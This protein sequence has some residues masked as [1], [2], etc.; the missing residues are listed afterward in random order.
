M[1]KPGHIYIRTHSNISY[2]ETRKISF[3]FVSLPVL[4]V[5][6]NFQHLSGEAVHVRLGVAGRTCVKVCV[7]SKGYFSWFA[8][9]LRTMDE[10]GVLNWL[11]V[12][13]SIVRTYSFN[14]IVRIR[15]LRQSLCKERELYYGEGRP[16]G[17]A[18]CSSSSGGVA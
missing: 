2:R 5:N 16:C 1:A 18:E 8:E 10:S 14:S 4:V 11:K 13:Y 17:I 15:F 12:I 7:D 6:V 9:F 3:S